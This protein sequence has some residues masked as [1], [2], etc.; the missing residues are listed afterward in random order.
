MWKSSV[1]RVSIADHPVIVSNCIDDMLDVSSSAFS[2][3]S[4]VR[5]SSSFPDIERRE[6]SC[7]DLS[8]AVTR[9]GFGNSMHVPVSWSSESD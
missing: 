6:I 2:T 5:C 8:F 4:A 3:R 1:L 9:L 7:H